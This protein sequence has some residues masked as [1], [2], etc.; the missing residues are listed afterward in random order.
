MKEAEVDQKLR[1]INSAQRRLQ[2]NNAVSLT[3]EERKIVIAALEF[4]GGIIESFREG[5]LFGKDAE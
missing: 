5:E 2:E 3:D 4:C 1:L